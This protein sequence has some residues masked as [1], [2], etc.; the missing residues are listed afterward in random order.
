M[1][2]IALLAAVVLSPAPPPTAAAAPA[3]RPTAATAAAAPDPRV[4]TAVLRLADLKVLDGRWA[5]LLFPGGSVDGDEAGKLLVALAG[6]LSP[7]PVATPAEAIDLL[8]ER[9]VISS[10]EYWTKN[11]VAGRTCDGRNLGEVVARVFSRLPMAVPVP[12]SVGA[13]PLA[14]TPA[15]KLRPAY[16]VVIAGAGTGGFGAAVQAARM[17]C[18][19]LLLDE[20]DYVGGQ[21][22]AAAVTSMDEGSTGLPRERGLYRELVG[23]VWAH[24]TK[25][26]LNPETAYGFRHPA[27]EPRVGQQICYTVLG[28]AKGKSG[29]LDVVLRST[30][31]KVAKRGEVVAG[32]EVESAAADGSKQTRPVACKVLVDAT[33]WGDVI[34]LT[35]AKYR[36]GNCLSDAVDRKRQIQSITWTAVVKQ[37]PTGVPAA[38]KLTDPP[39]GYAAMEPRFLKTLEV[40]TG[41]LA[42]PPAGSPW[43]WRRFIGY[44]AMP[45]SDRPNDNSRT[46]TRTHLNF[47]NDYPATVAD[48]EDPASR[49]ALNRAAILRTLQLL[50]YIQVK[51]GLSDWSVADDEGFDTP[52]NRAQMDALIAAQPELKPYAEVL[53]RFSVMAYARES[54]RIVGLHTLTSREIERKP[55][56]PTQFATGVALG[57]YA[58][59]LHG[60]MN[61][62]NLEPDLDDVEHLPKAFGEHG[63]GPF[64]IPF[65]SFIPEAVDGFLPAEKN[66]SQSKM[67]NGATRLQPSTMLMGQAVG[68]IAALA[69][70]GD[71]Q[72]RAVDPAAVQTALLDAGC[73]LAIHPV[74]APWGTAEWKAAQLQLLRAGKP[75]GPT[76]TTKAA[77]RP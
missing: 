9:N 72:P 49:Q 40:G 16:D 63:L 12:A 75:A 19:V 4:R 13:T 67:A 20:T 21:M 3:T 41:E 47:N 17:G 25:L 74:D 66:L 51:L 15:D 31:V 5:A 56:K 48:I 70:K 64:S 1:K 27:F 6:T 46:V 7:K 33:E 24:Y 23:H 52:Y 39:P 37:Y 38:L 58:V 44:R 43:S 28:D 34:P 45:N 65:E 10:K 77:T 29:T 26:G 50:Y 53:Q 60:S 8:A 59:D 30:V 11:A 32:V 55:G 61:K 42:K 35:G 73:T 62:P 54:R 68:A 71:V 2:H 76:T 22:N 14:P 36:V 69:V 18:S 57:D